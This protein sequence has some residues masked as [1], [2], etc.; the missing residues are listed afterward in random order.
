MQSNEIKVTSFRVS[1]EVKENIQRLTE[2]RQLSTNQLFEELITLA[3]KKSP[4]PLTLEENAALEA[5]LNQVLALFH[6]RATRLEVQQNEHER[7]SSRYKKTVQDL[8]QSVILES[9]QLKEEYEL[10]VS[11]HEAEIAQ[12][13]DQMDRLLAEKQVAHDTL[14]T[15]RASFKEELKHHKRAIFNLEGDLKKLEDER[16]QLNRQNQSLMD[17][18]DDL[19]ART[20]RSDQLEEENQKLHLEV[21][22]LRREKEVF[23]NRMNE[24]IELAVLR[25]RNHRPDNI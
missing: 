25:E 24:Q 9:E 16:T 5:A 23:E 2:Q 4:D 15:E 18:V 11:T 1:Q 22:L 7:I 19:K 8:E 13:Q 12:L 17:V 3:D 14:E 6:E 20:R 10:Q 21:Q